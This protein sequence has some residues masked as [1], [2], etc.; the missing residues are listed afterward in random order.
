MNAQLDCGE[1][2]GDDFAG[3]MADAALVVTARHA[4][5]GPSVE[6]ELELWHSFGKVVRD[7]GCARPRGDAAGQA[8]RRRLSRRPGARDARVVHRSGA[9]PVAGMR[10]AMN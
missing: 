7:T 5:R 8:D 9:G 3:Q 4:V 6:R 2:R 1:K 10:G